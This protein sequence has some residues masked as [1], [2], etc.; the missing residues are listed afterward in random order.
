[1][2][3]AAV[4]GTV[5]I[6]VPESFDAT[7]QA[8]LLLAMGGFD[9]LAARRRPRLLTATAADLVGLVRAGQF[10]SVLSAGG[11]NAAFFQACVCG[12]IL[13]GG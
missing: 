7:A 10:R 1:M 3:D 2:A 12:R 6:D 9:A 4:G 11:G 13:T 8:C 5:F